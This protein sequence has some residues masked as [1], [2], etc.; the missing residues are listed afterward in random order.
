M[1]S[2]LLVLLVDLT[3]EFHNMLFASSLLTLWL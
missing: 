1:N 2:V 3:K